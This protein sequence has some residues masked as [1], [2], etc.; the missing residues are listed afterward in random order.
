MKFIP[1][2][3]WNTLKKGDWIGLKY[4]LTK[5]SEKTQKCF[6][7][8]A[9]FEK[10]ERVDNLNKCI[11]VSEYIHFREHNFTETFTSINH[12]KGHLF[13]YN[14]SRVYLL[15]AKEKEKIMLKIIQEKI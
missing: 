3:K 6:D 11:K 9:L 13:T 14:Y 1:Q 10:V 4:K 2:E 5:F 7:W 12:N 15:T 8:I